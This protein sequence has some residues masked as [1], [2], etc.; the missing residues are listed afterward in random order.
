MPTDPTTHHSLRQAWRSGPARAALLNDPARD[1]LRTRRARRGL[2]LAYAAI[3]I[4][5][6]TALALGRPVWLLP[7]LAL[8]VVVIG[9]LNVPHPRRHRPA[10][11]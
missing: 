2:V 5:A 3:V 7:V 6:V 11:A 9:S 8:E 10:G 4:G 1:G